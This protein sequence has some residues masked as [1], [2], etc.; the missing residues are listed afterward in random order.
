MTGR[1]VRLPALVC[2]GAFVITMA[3][4]EF[5]LQLAVS[6]A[7]IAGQN[8]TIAESSTIRAAVE[9]RINSTIYLAIGLSAYLSLD[10][11]LEP[12]KVRRLL[13]TV[14]GHGR[15][16]RNIT[17][18]PDN[19]VEYI[20]PLKTNEKAIGLEYERIPEQWP[21]VKRAM[22]TG[23]TV[24]V[25]PIAL[26]QGGFGVLSRTPVFL[27]DGRYWGMASMVID[28]D[29]L[30]GEVAAAMPD[31][32]AVWALRSESRQDGMPPY[33]FGNPALFTADHLTQNV[34]VP[35]DE[36][37]IAVALRAGSGVPVLIPW[38]LRTL[39]T[40]V[41]GII[42]GLLYMVFR[43]RELIRHLA[44]HDPLTGLPNRRLL[45]ERVDQCVA[46]ADRHQSTF[47]IVYLDLDG[48]KPVNDG[49]GHHVGDLV[50]QETARR[51]RGNVRASDTVARIGGDEFV[52]LLPDTADIAGAEAL[53]AKV[54]KAIEAPIPHGT[55]ELRIG[56]SIGIGR[57]PSHGKTV[58]D[59]MNMADAAMYQAKAA[60]RGRIAVLPTAQS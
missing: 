28:V 56:A 42:A 52:L 3:F 1:F 9:G 35:G 17:V 47:C 27:E 57:Y 14:Y 51:L 22:D 54:Q 49:F 50:L 38:L 53:A 15:N 7:R 44:V 2:C 59:L 60:G 55:E 25:G 10:P 24:I 41:C 30:L 12:E 37:E 31:G 19:R 8:Q 43:E 32:T 39:N 58:E 29:S 45:F 21:A 23:E 4:G 33:I 13:A 5:A 48:F 6:R 20:Y 16:I 46:L 36:W 11:V 40:A 18:A 34:T 26:V